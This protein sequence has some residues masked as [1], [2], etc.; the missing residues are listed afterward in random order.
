MFISQRPVWAKRFYSLGQYFVMVILALVFVLPLLFMIASSM[1]S[2]GQILADLSSIRAFFPVGQVSFENYAYAFNFA[3]LARFL[4]NSTLITTVTV[5]TGL[6]V[7]S[8]AGFALARLR[9]QGRSLIL[10]VI[11]ATYIIPFEAFAIPLLLV[12]NNLP[13]FA[14][15][16]I[17]FG[18]LNTYRVQIVPFIADAFSIYLFVQFFKGIPQETFD[19]AKID[20]AN[21]FQIFLRIVVPL[22]GPVFATAAI[23]RFLAMW[24]QY[25]W[26]TLVVQT[27]AYRPIMVGFGYFYGDGV[28][29]AYLTI[30]TVPVLVFFFL[31]QN[32]FIQSISETGF[33]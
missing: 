4:L 8:L 2:Y 6:V 24:N 16:E 21:M 31:F 28:G 5:G 25:L 3:P 18:W 7:N 1:K 14:T 15:G 13:W 10:A 26:P 22:S 20:G 17:T 9:W 29:M 11:V 27:D 33:R 30:A 19:A 32:A 12:V 23:L